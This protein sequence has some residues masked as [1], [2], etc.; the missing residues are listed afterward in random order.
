MQEAIGHYQE[1][2]RLNPSDN[3]GTRN[4]L[5]PALLITGRNEEAGTL[6]EQFAEDIS[7][8]WKYGWAL[9]TFRREGDSSIARERLKAAI[10]ANRHVPRYLAGKAPWPGPLPHSYA[11][12]S[13][14]EAVITADELGEAWRATPGAERWLAV[15]RPKKKSHMRRRR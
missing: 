5:L 13:E 3:Q 4:I 2:L 6:L 9:W 1:L 8:A 10:R 15:A 7:A 14:E 11:F 12:G